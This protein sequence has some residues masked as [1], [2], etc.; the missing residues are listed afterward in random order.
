MAVSSPRQGGGVVDDL[1][2]CDAGHLTEGGVAAGDGVE[3]QPGNAAL[4]LRLLYRARRDGLAGADVLLEAA[5]LVLGGPR[6]GGYLPQV[7]RAGR[8]QLLLGVRVP[9][10]DGLDQ[11]RTEGID[12]C[13]RIA[14]ARDVYHR[15][16]TQMGGVQRPD[17]LGGA[18]GVW[19]GGAGRGGTSSALRDRLASFHTLL[20]RRVRSVKAWRASRRD[21]SCRRAAFVL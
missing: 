7:G 9:A 21:A 6:L 13:E 16:F 11:V 18:P 14:Q 5:G 20:D 12:L 1:A 2:V 3:A 4:L 10:Q 19:P 8:L 17:R 15:L